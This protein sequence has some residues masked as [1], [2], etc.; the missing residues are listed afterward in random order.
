MSNVWMS[1]CLDVRCAW[2]CPVWHRMFYICNHMATVV[3]KGLK[4]WGAQTESNCGWQ[5]AEEGDNT[6]ERVWTRVQHRRRWRRRR[7]LCVVYLAWRR[8]RHRR[9][10]SSRRSAA[11]GQ[12]CCGVNH[13]SIHDVVV[14]VA[15][16]AGLT[17]FNLRLTVAFNLTNCSRSSSP[18]CPIMCQASRTPTR[19][20]W[21]THSET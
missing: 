14:S 17:L 7:Y 3:V 6:Q 21:V 15:L 18:K 9:T 13:R 4:L 16:N 19:Y 2:M 8:G 12:Y 10:A 11:V 5:R 1:G 20:A